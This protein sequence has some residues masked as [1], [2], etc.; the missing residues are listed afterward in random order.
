MNNSLVKSKKSFAHTSAPWQEVREFDDEA[1]YLVD[2]LNRTILII[3]GTE[4]DDT[5]VK[6]KKERFANLSLVK[7]SPLLLSFIKSVVKE[8]KDGNYIGNHVETM[9]KQGE[10]LIKKATHN[11]LAIKAKSNGK[12]DI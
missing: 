10:E 12:G 5:Y 3:P 4:Y 7:T 11:P 2:E 6:N 1:F 8:L 9:I